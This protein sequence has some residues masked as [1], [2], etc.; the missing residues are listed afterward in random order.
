MRPTTPASA[1]VYARISHDPSGE[2]LG[3][4][5]QEADCL[6]EA[7]RRG[8]SIAQVYV[9]DDRS[10]FDTRKPRPEYQRL[11]NDIQLGLR[12][13]VMIWRLDRLHRQP[14]ELEEFIVICDKHRVALATVTGDVDLAT[15]QG[16]LLARTWGAFAAHECEIKS[17][18]MSRANL[19]RARHGIMRIPRGEYGFKVDGNIVN[20]LEATVI[21]EAAGRLLR[22]ES[23]RGICN[24]LNRRGIPSARK[25]LWTAASLRCML[26]NPRLAGW[27][28]YHGEVVG[29]GAWKAILTRRQSERI[30]SLFA[31]PNRRIGDG[32]R[33]CYLLTGLVHCGRCGSRMRSRGNGHARTYVCPWQ[34]GPIGCGRVSINV[35]ELNASFLARLYHRL[36]SEE[37]PATLQRGHLS[38]AKWRKAQSAMNGAEARLRSLARDYST[39][40]LSRV[41]WRAARP[42]LLEHARA[43]KATLLQN[44]TEDV[45][46]EF[47]GHA[48]DLRAVWAD[49]TPSRQRAIIGALAAEVV[50][51]PAASSRSRSEERTRIWWRGEARPRTP[52]GARRGI[53]ERRAA[54]E[55]AQCL[56][57]S[58]LEPYNAGGYCKL[59]LSRIT[60]HGQP[61]TAQRVR[62]SPYRG[63]LCATDS[64]ER[65]A[66]A[67]G[68]CA[69]HYDAWV[70]DDPTRPRCGVTDCGRSAQVGEWCSRHY[71]RLART[72]TTEL[73]PRVRATS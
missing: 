46:A 49:V 24:D 20:D 47:I 7:N 56:V 15:S 38:D 5:R 1:A 43:T 30:R 73:R 69:P 42:A 65:I 13:G 37:L 66:V 28:T 68:R 64:C 40:S 9:D 60:K 14:R 57:T 8:W 3:V 54:G 22:G 29:K 72:G 61:G 4:R 10:A 31:D 11:L 50:I 6:E 48:D 17:E 39:G 18:R 67:F 51:W 26:G 16:R 34:P 52:R 45:V 58:C 63:A 2:R 32:S 59:H 21:R 27:S 36:D 41:E 71:Q 53:A 12:D 23:L 44:R 19:E 25:V 35:D 70:R 33:R 55:F 62:M